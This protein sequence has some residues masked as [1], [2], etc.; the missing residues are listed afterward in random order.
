MCAV[1]RRVRDVLRYSG[2]AA[3]GCS[4]PPQHSSTCFA[5]LQNARV[6]LC[7]T[8]GGVGGKQAGGRVETTSGKSRLRHLSTP[9]RAARSRTCDHV[10]IDT[11]TAES[12]CRNDVA[13]G[14]RTCCKSVNHVSNP[15]R[16]DVR[17]ASETRRTCR[18]RQ[19]MAAC[20]VG[21]RRAASGSGSSIYRSLA[22]PR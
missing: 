16:P 11:S 20:R 14:S 3:A 2:L 6:G 12:R 19:E 4:P 7:R 8:C 1:S 15:T 22:R 9:T 10:G 17:R 21:P 13:G 5:P 18:F